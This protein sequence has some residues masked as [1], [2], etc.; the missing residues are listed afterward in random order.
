MS[1]LKKFI[2][3]MTIIAI[4]LAN[5]VFAIVA[6][7]AD[8]RVVDKNVYMDP[9][10][11]IEVR[12]D[13]LLAQMTLEEKVGQTTQLE[14]SNANNYQTMSNYIKDYYLGSILSGG[15]AVPINNTFVG[16]VEMIYAYQQAAI[17][18]PLGIPILYEID[19]IHGNG[20]VAGA[21]VFPHNIGLGAANNEELM[22]QIGAATAAEMRAVGHYGNFAPAIQ[23]PK[24]IRWGRT[25]EGFGSEYDI[26]AR[27][28]TAYTIGLQGGLPEDAS[29][30][31]TDDAN[32]NQY[33]YMLS[34]TSAIATMKHF[35]GEGIVFHDGGNNGINQGN[36]II[37][38]LPSD[39][40]GMT[41]EEL[42]ANETIAEL[43]GPY[44]ALTEAGAR[45]MM[46]SFTS[47]NGIKMH[48]Q[49]EL[50][51]LLKLPKEQG[52]MGFTGFVVSDY[53]AHD[54]LN[55][56]TSKI[57]NAQ[58]FNA[59]VDLAMVINDWELTNQTSGWFPTIIQNVNEGTI[60]IDR[61]DDAVRRILR[62]KFEM[63]LFE[64]PMPDVASLQ[65][66]I[67]SEEH[68][69]IARNAVRES[70][71]MLKN[72]NNII[73]NLQD[74]NNVM[75]A[76]RFADNIG[77]QSGGWTISWQGVSGNQHGIV[78]T[79]FLDTVKEV[80]DNVG[81]SID[82][83]RID[84]D[85]TNYE[86]II[87]ALGETPY[88]EGFGDAFANGSTSR[89][90]LQLDE[91]DV[92]A[93]ENVKREFPNTPIV[94]VLFSGRP[95]IIN[96]QLDD[97]DGLVVAWWPGSEGGGITDVLFGEYDF[98]GT[99]PYSWPWY[100]EWINDESKELM[101]DLGYGLKKGETG[102][103]LVAPARQTSPYQVYADG[104]R[105]NISAGT[106]GNNTGHA[107]L[108]PSPVKNR[109]GYVN[110]VTL[111]SPNATNFG[112][113]NWLEYDI[114]VTSDGTYSFAIEY[115]STA[116]VASGL[117]IDI[118]GQEV[119]S[120]DLVNTS[121]GV[122]TTELI[123]VDLEQGLHTLRVNYGRSTGVTTIRNVRINLSGLEQSDLNVN[124]LSKTIVENHAANVTVTAY[125][126]D[127]AIAKI[128]K[129]EQIIGSATFENGVARFYLTA[130]DT[131][132][133]GIYEVAIY[134]EFD[135]LIATESIEI[136]P[137]SESIFQV[138]YWN[139]SNSVYATFGDEIAITN[140]FSI[141][142]NGE[143][144]GY[145][146]TDND[147]VMFDRDYD[148]FNYEND[149][150]IKGLSLPRYF[151]SYTFTLSTKYDK[152]G[153]I[154]RLHQMAP[155]Y[156]MTVLASSNDS[157]EGSIPDP[158]KLPTWVTLETDEIDEVLY[159][160]L[161]QYAIDY[162]NRV[163]A[164][165]GLDGVIPS[166]VTQFEEALANAVDALENA[167]TQEQIDV[168]LEALLDMIH[169][170]EFKLADKTELI[171][172]EQLA[173]R[174]E[175]DKEL[176][177]ASTY[178]PFEVA[179][180][181]ARDL[182]AD[183]ELMDNDAVQEAWQSLWDAILGLRLRPNKE[184]LM[185]LLAEAKTHNLSLYTTESAEQLVVAMNLV[186]DVLE[187]D[188]ANQATVN[189]AEKV[190]EGAINNLELLTSPT[191]DLEV[192][193]V[194][195]EIASMEESLETIIP[196]ATTTASPKTF[197]F[198]SFIPILFYFIVSL[199]GY[200]VLKKRG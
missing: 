181:V 61:L 132:T 102:E 180:E 156:T 44:I 99:T 55:G 89:H 183:D 30:L 150:V 75:F 25:Y 111:V 149:I 164:E 159:R 95:M 110:P 62:V 20:N 109:Y 171:L 103:P 32:P 182:I 41:P 168:A 199:V 60:S 107:V 93:L 116:A 10:Q 8:E 1:K 3:I 113:A 58:M 84:G 194:N 46:P 117:T 197:D 129:G 167:T 118:D 64:N 131:K 13:A 108:E 67:Y 77:L 81:Y 88:A 39:L 48:Q 152:S 80:I 70:L 92:T 186:V 21:T 200:T 193:T 162:A 127:N 177:I 191:P 114:Y 29:A 166:V 90:T 133:I 101:F 112:N 97:I 57:R 125:I 115:L 153:G 76:G 43:I 74:M 22:E 94:V 82:G 63:G 147:T 51:D 144:D 185:N 198:Y 31:N 96:N 26:N 18:T 9:N 126:S 17:S 187:N 6:Q 174:Y 11:P 158:D 72:D 141:S 91:A 36:T 143:T 196:K 45:S 73:G 87:V 173:K 12:I 56:S 189:N 130:D 83:T 138:N 104:T 195:D 5:N 50:I 100:S 85:D 59:G 169:H 15:G 161:L 68:A 33:A 124:I 2:A 53:R 7:N 69:K 4:T 65:E 190:I 16:W 86:A 155:L 66:N 148:S 122:I 172:L 137:Y 71:V 52:G 146:S 139:A 176:Y 157:I 135:T 98:T 154:T 134:D 106:F 34:P 120:Y 178:A 42:M 23:T 170:L 142:V 128:E 160:D 163:K 140:H 40:T 145:V 119:A 24:N 184:R 175:Q 54:Q 179:L 14:R 123:D 27:L 47:I 38:D 192:P 105:T 78:G 35:L 79:T 151:S 165:G 49:K 188:D 19:A 37:F 136:L 28:A 121:N